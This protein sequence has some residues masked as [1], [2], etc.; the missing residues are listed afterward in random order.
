MAKLQEGRGWTAGSQ[1]RWGMMSWVAAKAKLDDKSQQGGVLWGKEEDDRELGKKHIC[2]E[3]DM[4]P[5]MAH[6]QTPVFSTS[7]DYLSSTTNLNRPLLHLCIQPPAT[8][9]DASKEKW[10]PVASCKAPSL[11]ASLI[12]RA[13]P[14]AEAPRC[15]GLHKAEYCFLQPCMQC[16]FTTSRTP[17]SKWYVHSTCHLSTL[18][19]STRSCIHP[20]NA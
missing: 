14:R 16:S 19:T 2:T 15:P 3:R 13:L 10:S 17:T 9:Y 6:L 7:M 8:A 11:P 20:F 5:T 4:W 18:Y 1:H 12:T